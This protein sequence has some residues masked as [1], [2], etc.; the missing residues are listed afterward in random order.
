MAGSPR[1]G[2]GGRGADDPT[3][4]P[5]GPPPAEVWPSSASVPGAWV[6]RPP[7]APGTRV[8]PGGRG[9]GRTRASPAIRG[10]AR[11]RSHKWEEASAKARGAAAVFLPGRPGGILGKGIPGPPLLCVIQG[12]PAGTLRT[13]QDEPGRGPPRGD[14]VHWLLSFLFLFLFFP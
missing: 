1:R 9:A 11:T 12:R 4:G 5:R 10:A 2:A 6:H 14:A 3:P 7:E 13:S 8:A